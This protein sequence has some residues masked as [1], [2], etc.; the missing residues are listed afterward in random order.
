MKLRNWKKKLNL[1]RKFYLR[2]FCIYICYNFSQ[3]SAENVELHDKVDMLKKEVSH[4]H[5]QI[6]EEQMKYKRDT[7][8]LA[9]SKKHL[10]LELNSRYSEV[11][12]LNSALDEKTQALK[13]IETQLSNV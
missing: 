8:S 3:V 7:Q 6:N 2:K 9:D 11:Q 12:K 4:L 10:Q 1:R 13:K 5:R